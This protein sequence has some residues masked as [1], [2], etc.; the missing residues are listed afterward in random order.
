METLTPEQAQKLKAL[1]QAS[2]AL[3]SQGG[4]QGAEFRTYVDGVGAEI[5]TSI[6][7]VVTKLTSP[8]TPEDALH[9]LFALK[10]LTERL[11]TLTTEINRKKERLELYIGANR[12]DLGRCESGDLSATVKPKTYAPVPTKESAPELYKALV[13]LCG[14]DQEAAELEVFRPHY[15]GI[16]MLAQKLVDEG[17]PVPFAVPVPTNGYSITIRRKRT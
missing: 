8:D 17:S 6:V 1:Q 16:Q 13:D 5:M 7:E 10:S 15:P 2:D 4:K 12:S 9:A 14:L 3:I 11:K